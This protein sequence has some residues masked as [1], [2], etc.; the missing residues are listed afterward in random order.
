MKL[1]T[2]TTIAREKVMALSHR[3]EDLG[4]AAGEAQVREKVVLTN[5]L[6]G[7][8]AISSPTSHLEL[9]SAL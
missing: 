1:F 2:G 5:R 6:L 9:Q 7:E 3:K 8:C 4:Q